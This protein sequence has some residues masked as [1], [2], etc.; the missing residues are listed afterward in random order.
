MPRYSY[1]AA[2]WGHFFSYLV[3]LVI[4]TLLGRKYYHI[5]YNWTRIIIIVAAALGIYGISCLLPDTLHLAW[6]LAIHTVFILVYIAGYVL[7]ELRINRK[8]P[9]KI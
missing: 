8:K 2:A 4:S 7:Y 1:W 5:P 9:N 6:K 3:M